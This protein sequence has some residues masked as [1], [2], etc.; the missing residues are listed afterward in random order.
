MEQYLI[1]LSFQDIESDAERARF[2]K[3]KTS[4]FLPDRDVDDLIEK[5]RALLRQHPEYQRLVSDLGG[6]P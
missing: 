6:A 1:V 3:M 2:Q 4:F 5:G